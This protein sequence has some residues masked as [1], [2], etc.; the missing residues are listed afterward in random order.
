MGCLTFE[1]ADSIQTEDRKTPASGI[2]WNSYH[3]FKWVAF[4]GGGEQMEEIIGLT[5]NQKK[6]N[7][8]SALEHRV[9]Q[10]KCYKGTRE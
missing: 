1:C 6:P 9:L 10:R 8:K 2:H 7:R 4:G 3:K 5:Y